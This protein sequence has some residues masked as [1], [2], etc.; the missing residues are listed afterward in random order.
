MVPPALRRSDLVQPVARGRHRPDQKG[1]AMLDAR[2]FRPA[3]LMVALS[4]CCAS[5]LSVPTPAAAPGHAGD[6]GGQLPGGRAAPPAPPPPAAA[7]PVYE[8]EGGGGIG[9]LPILLGLA[10]LGAAIFFLVDNDDDNPTSP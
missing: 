6:A 5:V 7:P 8:E 10:A 2:K 4:L 1:N 3:K 9:W